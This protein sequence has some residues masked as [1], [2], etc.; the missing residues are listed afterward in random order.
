MLV[1]RCFT[2]DYDQHY[3]SKVSQRNLGILESRIWREWE[4]SRHES[5]EFD[6]GVWDAKNERVG[7]D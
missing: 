4:D 6:K 3:D 2:N 5:F 1:R 7:D